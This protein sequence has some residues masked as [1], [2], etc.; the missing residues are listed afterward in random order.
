[1]GDPGWLTASAVDRLA[2]AAVAT[3]GTSMRIQIQLRITAADDSV[4]STDLPYTDLPYFDMLP[5]IIEA[6]SRS[7][8]V[9]LVTNRRVGPFDN[10]NI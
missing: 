10:L 8:F 2:A 5:M 3:I 1:M 9:F 7:I 6:D 4:I